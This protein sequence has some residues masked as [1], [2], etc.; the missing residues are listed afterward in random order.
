MSGKSVHS[1]AAYDPAKPKRLAQAIRL[2]LMLATTAC[3]AVGAAQQVQ[4]F[5]PV[6]S[7]ATLDGSTGFRLDGVGNDDQSGK[8]V[9]GAGDINGDGIDDLIIGAPYTDPVCCQSGS[10]YVVFG[11]T[12]PF[13]ITVSLSTLDGS[14]GFRL[15][16]VNNDERSGESVSGAGDINGDGIDDLI[17]GAPRADPVS[18]NEGSSYVL[19][20]QTAPFASS[21]SLSTLNGSNGFRLDGVNSLDQSGDSVSGAGDINGDGIDDLII[22]AHFADPV[23]SLEGSSYVVF[24]KVLPF[25]S[26]ITLPFANSN[27]GFRLDGVASGDRSGTS[28]SGAGDINGDGIDDLII[29]AFLADPVVDQEGS[30]YVVFG[31]TAPFAITVS[32]ST[33]DGS[34]GFRLDGVGNNDQSGESVSGAGDVNGDGIDDLIIGANNADPVSA[35]EG[36]SYVLFGR[37]QGFPATISLSN[38]NGGNGFR[39]DGV[40]S[41]DQSGE[42]VS[43][44][45]DINGDGIDDLIIGAP[46]AD[47]VIGNEGSSYV[48]FGQTA[49]FASSVSLSTLNGSNGFRLDGV[50]P[51]DSSG[52]WV[53]G[54]GDINSDGADDLIIGA[55]F[56]GPVSL[57]EGSSFVVFGEPICGRQA[58]L[59]GGEWKMVGIPCDPGSLVSEIFGKN[60]DIADYLV[61]WVVFERDEVLDIYRQLAL[62]D[63]LNEGDAVWIFS[64]SNANFYVGSVGI[65]ATA[66]NNVLASECLYVAGCFEILLTPPTVASTSRFNLVGHAHAKTIDWATVVIDGGEV[67]TPQEAEDANLVSKTIYDWNGNAYDSFDDDTP[68]MEG[69]FTPHGGRWVE[70]LDSAIG[71]TTVK[72]LIP[73]GAT[74]GVPPPPPG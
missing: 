30:S 74:L 29:G 17:I 27:V 9:S 61:E 57:S 42:S 71:A 19:F 73:F 67:L 34:N 59:T 54:A 66:P 69:V 41:G 50:G 15:D 28:V 36:S 25:A 72:M 3:L 2:H 45:G 16:G 22:G 39:L 6:I 14:N 35:N 23:S 38:L 68:G 55:P 58:A 43:G 47:P 13:A 21:V 48:V 20:G 60:F 46:F 12:A 24:G 40:N 62:T 32:L 53:S 64:T 1:S 63:N 31:Q 33:L 10:S 18:A 52:D 11:Q 37:T 4:A 49:P 70:V 7:L 8:S 26:S 5:D 44:A 56:A 51:S 65:I